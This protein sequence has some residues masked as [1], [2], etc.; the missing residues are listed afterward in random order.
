MDYTANFARQQI[1]L[2]SLLQ[3]KE[4]KIQPVSYSYVE[5]VQGKEILQENKKEGFKDRVK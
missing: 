2:T 4:G 5:W 3:I 1:H